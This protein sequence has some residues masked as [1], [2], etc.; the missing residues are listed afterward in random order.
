VDATDGLVDQ[1]ALEAA[2]GRV[3]PEYRQVLALRHVAGLD[4]A[5][6]ADALGLPIGTVRS[7]LAR[8][9]TQLLGQL[10]NSDGD[11]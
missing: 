5:E 4:Y 9:R 3:S 11:G 8:G 6:I 10:G 7:R 2:L 1:M